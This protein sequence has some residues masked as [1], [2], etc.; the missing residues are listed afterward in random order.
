MRRS[1]VAKF[2]LRES[3]MRAKECHNESG[4]NSVISIHSL[5][6]AIL[7]FDKYCCT[8]IQHLRVFV[9]S[10]CLRK[11]RLWLPAELGCR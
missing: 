10:I 9:F 11:N 4:E 5:Q 6:R 3:D 1:S 2:S 8:V 7:F